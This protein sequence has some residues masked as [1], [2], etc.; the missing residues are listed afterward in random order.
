MFAEPP[1]ESIKIT[2]TSPNAYHFRAMMIFCAVKI[3][4][5]VDG[6]M[7]L[8]MMGWLKHFKKCIHLL[9]GT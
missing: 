9:A 2:Y 1:G 4:L 7:T 8:P 3:I 5:S 6:F